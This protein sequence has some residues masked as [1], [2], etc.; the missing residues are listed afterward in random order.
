MQKI[1]MSLFV[2]I[3]LTSCGG[4]EKKSSTQTVDVLRP[5]EVEVD[6]ETT[7]SGETNF[8]LEAWSDNWFAMYNNEELVVEDSVSITT[9]KSFN[10]E[11]KK[12]TASYPLNLAFILKDY[13]EDDSG[14]EYIGKS[15]QQMWDG[16]FIMQ[17]TNIDTWDLVAV[18]DENM[19]CMVIHTAPLN[20][21]CEKSNDSSTCGFESLE[22]PTGW[23]T[24]TFDDSSWIAAT[25][26]SESD[27]S[28]KGGYD[29]ITW[30]SSAKLI[31]GPDLETN[32]T[33]LC[34][35][36]IEE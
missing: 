8:A 11:T 36:S 18:S 26:H 17:I 3:L 5:S 34:R 15:K 28:P 10:G 9:E 4:L 23:K 20:K 19:T 13:K 7:D 24:T 29:K 22:E 35:I 31:W 16:G 30:N 25:I 2:V 1:I 33:I 21:G 32:N 27:V 12:F 6:T 14:L